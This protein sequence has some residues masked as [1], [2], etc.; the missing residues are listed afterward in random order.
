MQK[1]VLL[2]FKQLSDLESSETIKEMTE[3]QDV[4]IQKSNKNEKILVQK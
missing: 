2:N 1:I 4:T 3:K